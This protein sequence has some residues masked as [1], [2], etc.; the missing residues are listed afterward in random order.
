M[1]LIGR[2]SNMNEDGNE[3]GKQKSDVLH[4]G[5]VIL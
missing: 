1:T 4:K 5:E 2:P 3:L